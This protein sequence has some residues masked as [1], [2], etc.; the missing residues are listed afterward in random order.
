MPLLGPAAMLLSFDLAPEAIL[1]H[2][3][4]HTHEHLPERLSIP[5]FLRG[6]RWVAVH[7]RPRYLV[8]YEVAELETLTSTAYLKRLNNPSAWTSKMM[9]HYRGMSRG[10]CSVVGSFGLGMGNMTYLVR[11]KAQPDAEGSLRR[12]LLDDV[13]SQIPDQRGVSGGHLLEGAATAQMTN[14]QRIRG[15]D[16]G[17]DSAL[18]LVGYE[19][20]AL[21]DLVHDVV[22]PQHLE[23]RG[24]TVGAEGLYRFHYGL[25]QVEVDA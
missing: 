4:W 20:Q 15:V 9:P 19:S 17:V 21:L 10:L 22:G 11:F 24:A 6:T 2:D 13:L 7:G 1:E 3:D 14:E 12:W 23:L 5:G 25:A 16:A 8:L 18:L